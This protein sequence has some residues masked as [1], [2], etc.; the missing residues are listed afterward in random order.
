MDNARARATVAVAEARLR[1]MGCTCEVRVIVEG[2]PGPF[3]S[4]RAVRA[5]HHPRCRMV[6]RAAAANN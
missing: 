1:E 3:G 2:D 5:E 4:V 6:M